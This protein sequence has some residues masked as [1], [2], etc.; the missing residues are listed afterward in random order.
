MEELAA[1]VNWAVTDRSMTAEVRRSAAALA[2]RLGFRETVTA[3]IA[4]AVT[5]IC[6]NLLKHAGGGTV[7]LSAGYRGGLEVFAL[8]K[9]PGMR[10]VEACLG[11]GYSTAGSSGTGLGAIRRLARCFDIYSAP[12]KGTVLYAGFGGERRLSASGLRIGGIRTAKPGETECG[13]NWSWRAIGLHDFI[14]VA[15]GLGHGPL[16]ATASSEALGVFRSTAADQPGMILQDVHAALRSTRGAAVAVARIDSARAEVSYAGLG[17]I[18]GAIVTAGVVR[19]M[20]SYNGIAGHQAQK[21]AEFTYPW[22]PAAAL[23]MCSDGLTTQWSV[24]PYPGLLRHG[25]EVI[26]GVLYRDFVRGR[27]DATVVVAKLDEAA[28]TGAR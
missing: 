14:I 23:I 9:G 6:T 19:H 25:P 11:D 22:S 12:Q 18:L 5:E 26:A 4:I 17:N 2:E 8:D 7:M 27:D 15:D 21:I 13:D 20:V 28:G 3:D 1:G 16:A 10:D 24:Q